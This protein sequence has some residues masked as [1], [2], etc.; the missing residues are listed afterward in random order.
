MDREQGLH[1]IVDGIAHRSLDKSSI[2]TDFVLDAVKIT[3]L[4]IR[5]LHV[6]EFADGTSYG[7]GISAVA[8]LS[9]SHM[10]VHTIPQRKMIQVDL[11]SCKPF[12]PQSIYDLMRKHFEVSTFLLQVERKR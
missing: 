6:Q 9:E 3:G 8:L 1:L 11:F 4:T 5:N 2:V 12:N 10:T 7:P